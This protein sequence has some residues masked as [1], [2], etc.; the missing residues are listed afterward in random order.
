MSNKFVNKIFVGFISYTDSPE[1][2][3]FFPLSAV[4][5]FNFTNIRNKTVT[6][7][8]T[9]YGELSNFWIITLHTQ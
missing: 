4:S 2:H 7:M 8:T 3:N 9:S 1:P 6:V 5:N